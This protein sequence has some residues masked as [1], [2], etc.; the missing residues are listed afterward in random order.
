[1]LGAFTVFAAGYL[2]R[3]LG[4][5]VFG[6]MGDRLGR[7]KA[8]QLSVAFMAG[9]TVLLGVLP[10]Y[11]Q[12]GV[13]ATVALVIARLLQGFSVG[14]ELVGSISFITEVAPEKDR[15]FFGSLTLFSAVAGVMLGSGV[16]A[17]L[18]AVMS[19]ESLNAWG[20]RLPFLAGVI[21]VGFGIWIRRG[22]SESPDFERV[23]LEGRVSGH[24]VLE[25][26]R[27]HPT[28]I[29]QILG[30]VATMSG[31]FY[32]LFLWWPTYLTNI[33]TPPVPHAL[34]INTLC[35]LLFVL[36]IPM[37]GRLSDR[38]TQKTVMS[39]GAGGLIVAA[40][41]L[42]AWVDH[43]V[44]AGA[45]V[46]GAV[47]AVLVGMAKG[48]VPSAMAGLFPP[49][50]RYSGIALGYNLTQ[51]LVGG[52]SPMIST[53]LIKVTGRMIAPAYFLIFLAACTLI[54]SL[55]LPRRP[56][57]AEPAPAASSGADVIESN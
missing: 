24:P 2:V 52:T 34:G 50:Y 12:I 4:G 44:M 13:A 49:E 11:D 47:F 28:R 31:G 39:L 22:M 37:A 55:L 40:L 14:G 26:I 45:A 33:V 10:T 32:M 16:A 17:L 15:G 35:M 51:A 3:P 43:G 25:V 42:F 41:P 1:L 36:M 8:L 9:P 56:V 20:W 21:V 19:E 18:H 7:K 5:I 29:V 46:S 53:W 23:R 27:R 57:E 38:W 48:P 54:A 30:L 6:R